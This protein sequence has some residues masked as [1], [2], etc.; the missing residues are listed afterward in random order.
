[1][2]RVSDEELR[3]LSGI[4]PWAFEMQD[5]PSMAR[6]LIAARKCVEQLR[7]CVVPYESDR[8][9]WDALAAYDEVCK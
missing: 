4:W 2:P 1:M 6:E 7:E 5:V 8:E 3:R 9:A